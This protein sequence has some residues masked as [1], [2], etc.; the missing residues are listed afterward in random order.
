MTDASRS[1]TAAPPGGA[2][3]AL[4]ILIAMVVVLA[5]ACGDKPVAT[6]PASIASASARA[7]ASPAPTP[8]PTPDPAKAAVKAFVALV[9]K[10][11][12][13]YQA[14]FS[15]RSR[16]AT[17]I[18]PVTKG[19]LQVSGKNVLVRATFKWPGG[20]RDAVEHRYVGGKA[21]IRYDAIDTYHR[22]TLRGADTMAAFA[23]I[24]TVADVTYLGPVKSG[25][26]T[27]YQVSFRSAIVNPL[28]IPAA[29]LTETALTSPKLTLLID[30]A[31]K[32]VRGTAEID[33]RG[34]V[35]GQL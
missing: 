2:R 33:G 32:P 28:M 31:G 12:F 8:S 14:T 15:G 16:H 26:K 21:W 13:S 5:A 27:Y 4:A 3:P 29:N 34:R 10:D 18:L 7:G 1:T 24:H 11:G 35:S 6:N 25:G 20:N 30:A 19:L 17:D 9:T 23:A 22:V